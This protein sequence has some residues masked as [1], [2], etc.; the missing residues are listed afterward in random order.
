MTLPLLQKSIVSLACLTFLASPCFADEGMAAGV[1]RW[2]G[3]YGG[4][5]IGSS[6]GGGLVDNYSGNKEFELTDSVL[7]FDRQCPDLWRT[8]WL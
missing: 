4:L 2:S 3:L 7:T 5:N 6:G 1:D 8:S